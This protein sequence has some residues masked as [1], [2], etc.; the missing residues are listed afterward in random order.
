MIKLRFFLVFILIIS[1]S[2]TLFVFASGSFDLDDR[3]S[4]F[5]YSSRSVG[6]SSVAY[7]GTFSRLSSSASLTFS[8]LGTGFDL[9]FLR[10]SNGSVLSIYIDGIL[11]DTLTVSAYSNVN[12]LRSSFSVS[13][14]VDSS[15]FCTIVV[16]DQ[17]RPNYNGVSSTP[18]FYFDSIF[19]NKLEIPSY[20]YD[21]AFYIF[22]SV[23]LVA[24]LFISIFWRL[25]IHD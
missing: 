6:T 24:L 8:F 7:S 25:K 19:V 14:L 15:H 18:Y 21:I 10:Y 3:D 1:L 20:I 17:N 13:G 2:L 23:C 5:S 22:I 16:S 11:Y 4:I 9:Y 12:F